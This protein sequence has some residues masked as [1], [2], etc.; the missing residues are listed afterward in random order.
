MIEHDWNNDKY[1][2]KKIIEHDGNH[3]GPC[4]YTRNM[5][6]YFFGDLKKDSFNGK[7]TRHK[8]CLDAEEK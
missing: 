8:R 5:I 2:F 3:C 4:K 7:I 6:C 1:Y